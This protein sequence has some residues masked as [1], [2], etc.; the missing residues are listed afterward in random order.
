[1]PERE[2]QIVDQLTEALTFDYRGRR[3]DAANADG[4]W[5]WGF[6]KDIDR[7]MCHPVV[8]NCMRVH[9]AGL[10]LA[11][12]EVISASNSAVGEWAEKEWR[13][14]WEMYLHK[15]QRGDRYGWI[16]GELV[17]DDT[18]GQL[19]LEDIKV[20]HAL[21]ARPLKFA[22]GKSAQFAGVRIKN[23]ER[24]GEVDLR[25]AGRWPGKAFWYAH[26]A[27]FHTYYGY[28][29]LRPSH[30]HWQRL[31]E[32]QGVE[33]VEDI[34]MTRTAIAG[35]TIRYPETA[36]VSR[37]ASGN[38]QHDAA[39]QKARKMMEDTLAGMGLILSSACD[40]KGKYHWDFTWPENA[41]N[42]QPLIDM[43]N[44]LES[45]IAYGIGTPLELVRA[46]QGGGLNSGAGRSITM[47]TFLATQQRIARSKT[48]V[49][50]RHFA[51]ATAK[52]NF[53]PDATFALRVKPLIQSRNEMNAGAEGPE[54]LVGQ[55]QPGQKMNSLPPRPGQPQQTNPR[56]APPRPEVPGRQR[57]LLGTEVPP[58][59]IR[60]RPLIRPE[61]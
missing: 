17:Y 4:Q 7:M 37:D 56:Q 19:S 38:L 35:P 14:Y 60:P 2:E 61:A 22:H 12:V 51:Q 5:D 29:Q 6:F 34:A 32:R 40:D 28:S 16:G 39:R 44:H 48:L 10:S 33:E 30:R 11:D 36:I 41:F 47:E 1:M 57:L 13:K 3:T 9:D 31:A 52:F 50:Y 43:D 20:F 46:E 42:A 8:V 53:G 49:W 23:L 45:R 59:R 26:E 18:G 27:D 15:V 54:A 25:P 24:Q 58:R 21:D 55:P